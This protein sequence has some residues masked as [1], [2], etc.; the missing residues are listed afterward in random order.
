MFTHAAISDFL[1]NTFS[2]DA[3]GA[4]ALTFVAVYCATAPS[5]IALPA[6]DEAPVITAARTIFI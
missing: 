2:I 4:A 1:D 3:I 5:P 6:A